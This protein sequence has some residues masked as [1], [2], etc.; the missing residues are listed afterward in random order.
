MSNRKRK[1]AMQTPKGEMK[2]VGATQTSGGVRSL[3]RKASVNGLCLVAFIFLIAFGSACRQDMQDQP[4][5]EA[6][7][8]SPFFKDNISSRP[9]VEGTVPRGYLRADSLLYTGK[10]S[11]AQA[12]SLNGAASAQ[13]QSQNRQAAD[14]ATPQ[15]GQV[16]AGRNNQGTE[17]TSS[18]SA[19][20]SGTNAQ[21]S[22]GGAMNTQSGQSAQ[23][24]GGGVS[25]NSG[26]GNSASRGAG[27]S[28]GAAGG[29]DDLDATAFPFPVTQEV[30][31]RGKERFEIFCS[32]CHGLTGEGDGMVVRRGF[33]R[34]PTYYT[35]DLRK[36]RVG[37]FFDV[38]TNGWG[39]MP[40]YAAQ[41][42][43]QDRW[44]IIAYIRALQ[45]S[46]PPTTNTGAN[47][48]AGNAGQTNGGGK[49]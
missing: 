48:A 21:N 16:A 36:A 34:P 27:Q 15:D 18:M 14:N 23:A 41:I 24:N 19:G 49:R 1:E 30:L 46:Q 4:R 26:N 35:D 28:S 31:T 44:A 6:Y 38:I 8:A 29:G 42:P 10:M 5:Y 13:G 33:R 3:S 12:S 45:L 2:S 43:A 11:P 7:E 47:G 37:H 39:S 32:M 22:G 20:T 9:L 40:N 17:G 25:S